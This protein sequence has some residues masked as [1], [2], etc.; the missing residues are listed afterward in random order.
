MN[1]INH[2][3]NKIEQ[4]RIEKDGLE[5]SSNSTSSSISETSSDKQS[6]VNSVVIQPCWGGMEI[7]ICSG[8]PGGQDL[9]LSSVLEVLVIQEGLNVVKCA[10]S[11]ANG[12]LIH[13]IQTEV[14]M[15]IHKHIWI[16]YHYNINFYQLRVSIL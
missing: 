13:T 8:G 6:W 10:S 3:K 7:V 14:Y 16:N 15:Y 12:R 11:K 5:S 4:L 9:P 1:H 2:M